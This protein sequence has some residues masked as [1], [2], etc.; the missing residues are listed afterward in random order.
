MSST[1]V[2][3]RRSGAAA[4]IVGRVG[5]AQILYTLVRAAARRDAADFEKF[6][7]ATDIPYESA[8]RRALRPL[9]PRYCT[10][11]KVISSTYRS[12]PRSTP[13]T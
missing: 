1:R 8:P 6:M 13:S 3:G 4:P 2:I 5:S 12:N 11:S 10:K 7:L 9:S